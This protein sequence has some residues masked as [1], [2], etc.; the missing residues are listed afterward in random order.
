MCVVCTG[1]LLLR[2]ET[3]CAQ[4]A[5]K[6][7]TAK[8]KTTQTTKQTTTPTQNHQKRTLEFHLSTSEVR[9]G[10]MG[11]AAVC[12]LGHEFKLKLLLRVVE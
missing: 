2:F 7:K 10:E 5:R 8:P 12:C 6:G 3:P 4:E 11:T 9:H 1:H